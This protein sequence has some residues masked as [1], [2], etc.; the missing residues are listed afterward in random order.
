LD[1]VFG[2]FEDG[3]TDAMFGIA[4]VVLVEVLLSIIVDCVV[5]ADVLVGGDVVVVVG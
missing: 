4:I 1:V 2:T 3:P 5:A